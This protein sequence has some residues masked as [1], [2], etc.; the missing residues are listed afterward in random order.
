L[1]HEEKI[2]L[3]ESEQAVENGIASEAL[4]ERLAQAPTRVRSNVRWRSV[5]SCV[6][7]GLVIL[8]ATSVIAGLFAVRQRDEANRQNAIAQAGRLAAQ[9]DLL[10]ERGGAMDGSV[11]L[12]IEAERKLNSVGGRSLE[13]DLS[14]RRALALLPQ[15]HGEFSAAAHEAKLSPAGDYANFTDVSGRVEV[16]QVPGGEL[17]SCRQR[18]IEAPRTDETKRPA[19]R[20]KAASTN[21][22]WCVIE[23]VHDE[24]HSTLEVWSARPSKLVDSLPIDT[25]ASH[26]ALAV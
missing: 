24:Y 17:R 1:R 5:V 10:R 13:V 6:I 12:A 26:L 14:L 20:V 21:G 9:A 7:A 3:D 15:S 22:D 19:R 4:V 16:F 2:W 18:D 11:M 25:T 8:T 23:E